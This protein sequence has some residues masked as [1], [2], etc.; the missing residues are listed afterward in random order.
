MVVG[1]IAV[2]MWG[3]PRATA[4]LDVT[5]LTDERGLDALARAVAEHGLRID[6]RWLDSNPLLR[7]Q[8]VRLSG[9]GAI[10]DLMRPRDDHEISAVPRR[11][12]L[13]VGGQAVPFVAPDD[14]ILMKLKAGRPHDFDDAVAVAASQE[15]RLDRDYLDDWAARLGL[16]D[17]LGWVLDAASGS[18][19]DG[20]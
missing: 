2:A 12:R 3:R 8:H 20:I 4:D 16:S 6:E 14:L 5:V 18:A 9:E 17:E 10:I 1:A 15:G 11:R 13:D 19:D 7:G